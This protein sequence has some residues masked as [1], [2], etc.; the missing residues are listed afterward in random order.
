MGGG[1]G[2][3]RRGMEQ[4]QLHRKSISFVIFASKK[5]TLWVL[6]GISSTGIYK[7]CLVQR[8][9]KNIVF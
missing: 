8:I 6:I 2:G 9:K 3:G 7:S 5:H 4:V 1:R